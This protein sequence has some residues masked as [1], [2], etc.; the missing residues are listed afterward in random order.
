M[1][2]LC[3]LAGAGVFITWLSLA[4]TDAERALDRLAVEGSNAD[5]VVAATKLQRVA[6]LSTWDASVQDLAA[7]TWLLGAEKYAQ[8][9]SLSISRLRS[10][11]SYMRRAVTLR[12]NWPYSWLNLARIEFGLDRRG[13]WQTTLQRALSLNLRGTFLQLDLLRFRLQ[14][15]SHLNGELARAVEASLARGVL[16]EPFP[17]IRAAFEIGRPEWACASPQNS[18]IKRFCGDFYQV[19]R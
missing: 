9:P 14:L 5:W 16:D 12:P 19:R 15:G 7:R 13:V 17:M 11:R 4:V 10:A 2:A 18:E 6:A 3:A 8:T 1:L